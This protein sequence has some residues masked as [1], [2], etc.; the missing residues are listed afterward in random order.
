MWTRR[1][2][3]L[4]ACDS[5]PLMRHL[6][7]GGMYRSHDSFCARH[8]A[9]LSAV[10]GR[11]GLGI[12]THNPTDSSQPDLDKRQ[13]SQPHEP[14]IPHFLVSS[15]LLLTIIPVSSSST[16]PASW[17]PSA[18]RSSAP[19]RASHPLRAWVLR[20]LVCPRRDC[21]PRPRPRLRSVCEATR[22]RTRR[23]P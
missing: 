1:R 8:V 3:C 11:L 16:S 14:P 5:R 17:R 7:S 9:S 15:L 6:H 2:T 13:P 23:S 21:R 19:S 4:A 12:S 10:S 20:R 18:R 22:A